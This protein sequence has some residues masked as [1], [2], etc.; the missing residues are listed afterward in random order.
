[1]QF[2]ILFYLLK[3]WIILPIKLAS[4]YCR[5]KLDTSLFSQKEDWKHYVFSI[6]T[7]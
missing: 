5:M 4:Y 6:V 3:L 1:M 7:N 2:F